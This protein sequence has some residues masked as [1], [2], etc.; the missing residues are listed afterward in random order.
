MILPYLLRRSRVV[1]FLPILPDNSQH[2]LRR[3]WPYYWL[4]YLLILL[5]TIHAWISMES[6]HGMRAKMTGLWGVA[7][8]L[9]LLF[10]QVGSGLLLRGTMQS[11]RMHLRRWH[12]LFMVAIAVFAGI[13]VWLNA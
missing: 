6:G 11:E 13:H 8:A 3:M 12:F 9:C 2:D 1:D 4:G 5:A 10:L 7:I